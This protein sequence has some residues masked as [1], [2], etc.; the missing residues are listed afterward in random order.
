MEVH[1]IAPGITL[2]GKYGEIKTGM[3]LLRHGSECLILEMP[4]VTEDDAAEPWEQ[5]PPEKTGRMERLA[6]RALA[7]DVISRSRV[8]ELLGEPLDEFWRG[9]T[10]EN[11]GLPAALRA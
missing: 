5:V 3:W 6:L 8:A 4:E 11:D 2:Y 9:E 7:E 1:H 10:E